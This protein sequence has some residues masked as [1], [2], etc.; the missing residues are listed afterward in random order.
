MTATAGLP[1]LVGIE[2]FKLRR[3]L[4]LLLCVAAP[5]AVTLLAFLIALDGKKALLWAMYVPG[6]AA[7]WAY[8]ML[9]MTV[10]ALTLLMA[11]MEHAPKAWNH[12]FALPIARWRLFLAKLLTV[13]GL[14]TAMSLALLPLL[15]ASGSG[16]RWLRPATGLAGLPDL[17]EALVLLA[18]IAA[19]ALLMIVIHLW[20]ALRFASFVPPLVLGIGGTFVAVAATTARQGIY[21]P[22]LLPVNALSS[23][24]RAAFALELGIAG[25]VI[26]CGAMLLDLGRRR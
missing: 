14:V 23:D 12:L 25:G 10:T 16:A 21:F 3:S 6:V 22:W 11:Q 24:D 19:G 26:A 15:V 2:L 7:M 17:S 20:A 4:A 1:A 13:C 5:S 8:F 18:R 9:P